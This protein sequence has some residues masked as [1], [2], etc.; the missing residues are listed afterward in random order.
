[1]S[2]CL[3]ADLIAAAMRLVGAVRDEGPDEVAAVLAD[4]DLRGLCVTLAAMV[5]DNKTPSELLQWNDR[6]YG[7]RPLRCAACRDEFVH[8]ARTVGA[9][10]KRCPRCRTAA[11]RLAAAVPERCQNPKAGTD[12]GYYHHVRRD[13]TPTCR[14]CRAAHTAAQLRRERRSLTTL[15]LVASPLPV[16]VG[17]ENN[18]EVTL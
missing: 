11:D 13:K 3:P 16:V 9:P 1:M 5:P 12:T 2:D 10:P 8:P 6:R 14:A 7:P 4:V 15:T 17:D 18:G